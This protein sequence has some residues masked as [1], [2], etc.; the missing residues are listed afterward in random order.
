MKKIL[1]VP[2]V[3]QMTLRK[4]F[5]SLV[6]FAQMILDFPLRA[7]HTLDSAEVDEGLGHAEPCVQP[8]F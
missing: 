1:F 4:K 2:D 7:G 8:I 3:A 6:I 5:L